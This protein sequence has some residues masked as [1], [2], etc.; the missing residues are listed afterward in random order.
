MNRA[1]SIYIYCSG[2]SLIR[3]MGAILAEMH[4]QVAKT[5]PA[6]SVERERER[7]ARDQGENPKNF[8]TIL[9][10]RIRQSID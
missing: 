9:F 1:S 6:T 4:F 7:V 2:V 8:G 10:C 5:P 3:S